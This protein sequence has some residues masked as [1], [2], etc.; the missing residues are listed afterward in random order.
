M[1]KLSPKTLPFVI[2]GLALLV[3]L[4]IPLPRYQPVVACKPGSDCPI[5]GW[6]WGDSVLHRLVTKIAPSAQAPSPSAQTQVSPPT[7][8]NDLQASQI[9]APPPPVSNQLQNPPPA[10]PPPS[11]SFMF[12]AIGTLIRTDCTNGGAGCFEFHLRVSAQ[13]TYAL[14][15]ITD[16]DNYL[17]KVVRVKGNWREAGPAG[18]VEVGL[19]EVAN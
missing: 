4:V 2:A 11:Q 15:G 16:P 10:A 14:S 1:I 8:P 13:E 19:I 6:H 7:P 12:N 17:G 9:Q 18:W 5:E 3:A